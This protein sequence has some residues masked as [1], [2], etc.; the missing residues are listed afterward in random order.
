MIR[1]ARNM[2]QKF[3]VPCFDTSKLTL[4][5]R[6]DPAF[7]SVDLDDMGYNP[8]TDAYEFPCRCGTKGGFVITTHDL[9]TGKDFVQCS[10]CSSWVRVSYEIAE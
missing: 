1:Y 10:G 2:T 4:D 9:E 7:V 5:G 6:K 3:K 8:K